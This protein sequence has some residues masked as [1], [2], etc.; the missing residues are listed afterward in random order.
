M[1]PRSQPVAQPPLRRRSSGE[2]LA[3]TAARFPGPTAQAVVQPA[4]RSPGKETIPN[5][6]SRTASGAVLALT[7][8]AHSLP[9]TFFSK[10]RSRS[11]ALQSL[12]YAVIALALT[13]ELHLFFT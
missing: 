3:S 5:F 11:C 6:G 13:L 10:G 12:K 1:R 4:M 2:P 7:T 9:C 8:H